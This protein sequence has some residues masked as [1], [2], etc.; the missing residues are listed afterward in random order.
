[1]CMHIQAAADFAASAIAG[2]IQD[3]S[4]LEAATALR[5]RDQLLCY[6]LQPRS[7]KAVSDLPAGAWASN[8]PPSAAELC[9]ALQAFVGWTDKAQRLGTPANVP[10]TLSGRRSRRRLPWRFGQRA[11]ER[12]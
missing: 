12:R 1:M 7:L 11:D 8:E 10:D 2:V 4:P 6:L 3:S 9:A 5:R